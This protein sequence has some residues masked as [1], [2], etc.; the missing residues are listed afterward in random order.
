MSLKA[1]YTKANTN[2][3]DDRDEWYTPKSA[4]KY[5]E[6][7]AKKD[8]L[9]VWEPCASQFGVLARHLQSLNR[10]W[11]II[12]TD[13]STGHDFLTCEPP[14]AFDI[15][16]TNPPF[17]NK[18]K[19]FERAL[20]YKK[21][22]IFLCSTQSM[23]SNPLKHMFLASGRHVSVVYPCERINFIPKQL[24]QKDPDRERWPLRESKSFFQSAWYCID[25]DVPAVENALVL[26]M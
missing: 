20:T 12:Q 26:R 14:S 18:I 5:L 2:H 15:I 1:L 16:V 19:F 11:N 6:F 21:P 25:V 8:H 9:T 17:R 13:I 4:V 24:Y 3:A 22:V 7:L 10:T 23:D